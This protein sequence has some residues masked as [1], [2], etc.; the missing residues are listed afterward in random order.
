MAA[1][2]LFLSAAGLPAQA[3]LRGHGGFVKG[4]AVTADGSR[5]VGF[6]RKADMA[7]QWNY[8]QDERTGLIV[9]ELPSLAWKVL[10]YGP[11]E[12][13]YLLTGETGRYRSLFA[14]IAFTSPNVTRNV[15]MSVSRP[16]V[17]KTA[18]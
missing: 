11:Y 10:D 8:Q 9:V 3:E 12:P 18:A 14:S 4:I 5:A 13:A 17:A 16:Q 2:C 15:N 7:Q 1:L 6:T